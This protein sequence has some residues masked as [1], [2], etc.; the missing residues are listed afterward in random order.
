MQARGPRLLRE[1]PHHPHGRGPRRGQQASLDPGENNVLVKKNKNR[2]CSKGL[3]RGFD[4]LSKL[5]MS[6]VDIVLQGGLR[7]SE[8]LSSLR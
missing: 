1:D 6:K 8:T 7:S 5:E 2:L 3:W 4:H